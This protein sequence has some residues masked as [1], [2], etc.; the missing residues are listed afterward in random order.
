M[1]FVHRREVL[2]D[3]L[4]GHVAYQEEYDA[5]KSEEETDSE[6]NGPLVMDHL[7]IRQIILREI[8][9]VVDHDANRVAQYH[10]HKYH[11]KGIH[12][13]QTP[14]YS[15]WFVFTRL[16]ESQAGGHAVDFEREARPH[17]YV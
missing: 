10:Q 1:G 13:F 9:L 7:V 15:L 5:D 2:P 6:V 11:S 16:A 8:R 3:F 17:V 14:F 4:D 12:D